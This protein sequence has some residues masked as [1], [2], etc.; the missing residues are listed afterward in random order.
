MTLR[1]QIKQLQEHNHKLCIDN[2]RMRLE[3]EIVMDAPNGRA[4][5]KILDK[6]R[7]KRDRRDEALLELQN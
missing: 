4:A 6:Y 3:F 7:R 2:L 1:K 5:K